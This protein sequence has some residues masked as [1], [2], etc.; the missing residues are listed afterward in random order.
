MGSIPTTSTKNQN[1]NSLI[2]ILIIS[3][4]ILPKIKIQNNIINPHSEYLTIFLGGGKNNTYYFEILSLNTKTSILI[5]K[6]PSVINETKYLEKFHEI[7]QKIP[8][9]YKVIIIGHSA[10]SNIAINDNKNRYKILM[11]MNFEYVPDNSIIINGIFD[12]IHPPWETIKITQKNYYFIWANHISELLNPQSLFITYRKINPNHQINNIIPSIHILINLILFLILTNPNNLI[13]KKKTEIILLLILAIIYLILISSKQDTFIYY[14]LSKIP[15]FIGLI[16][17]GFILKEFSKVKIEVI[18]LKIISFIILFFTI[19][20]IINLVNSI[21]FFIIYKYFIQFT[22]IIWGTIYMIFG[23]TY[24]L[25]INIFNNL[26]TIIILSIILIFVK[27]KKNPQLIINHYLKYYYKY[28]K[29]ISKENL[30]KIF[31]ISLIL[32]S[33]LNT[34]PYYA[35]GFFISDINRMLIFILK[36]ISIISLSIYLYLGYISPLIN[37]LDTRDF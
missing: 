14:H 34:L 11:G 8:Q 33:I 21:P 35:D 31:L 1:I 6:L 26:E 24:F 15:M 16:I 37:K 5:E 10:G 3:I 7:N 28:Q 18:Q 27:Y 17:F 36:E 2:A 32:S 20:F 30:S 23:N 19:S 12:E 29:F 25:L 4:L 13:P 9:H 22:E